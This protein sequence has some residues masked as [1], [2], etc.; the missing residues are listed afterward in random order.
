MM[1]VVDGTK[2]RY[3]YMYHVSIYIYLKAEK[4][5][6]SSTEIMVTAEIIMDRK[7]GDE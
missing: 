6:K 3:R 7:S 1:I 4:V 5:I 2:C